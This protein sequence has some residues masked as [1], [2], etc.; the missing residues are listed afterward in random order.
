MKSY[1]VNLKVISF[2]GEGNFTSQE[3]NKKVRISARSLIVTGIHDNLFVSGNKYFS[4]WY[5]VK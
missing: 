4:Y 2:E 1:V 5:I 3:F